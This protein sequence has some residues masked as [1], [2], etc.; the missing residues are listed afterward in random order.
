MQW[1]PTEIEAHAP[2]GTYLLY[3][4]GDFWVAKFRPGGPGEHV[5]RGTTIDPSEGNWSAAAPAQAACAIH[6][7]RMDRGDTPEQAAEW[8]RRHCDYL[9]A[10]MAGVP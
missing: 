10:A 3:R 8:V 7:G 1:E 6:K 2:R 4:V 9:T 5:G